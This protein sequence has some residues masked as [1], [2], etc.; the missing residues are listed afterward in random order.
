MG[1]QEEM[2]ERQEKYLKIILKHNKPEFKDIRKEITREYN[3]SDETIK[4]DLRRLIEEKKIIKVKKKYFVNHDHKDHRN[5]IRNYLKNKF[6]EEI[7]EGTINMDAILNDWKDNLKGFSKTETNYILKFSEDLEELEDNFLI[8]GI[9]ESKIDTSLIEEPFSENFINSIGNSL[10]SFRETP[11]FSD[12]VEFLSIKHFLLDGINEL[13]E[14]L[15][16][17]LS[18]YFTTKYPETKS[19]KEGLKKRLIQAY[20]KDL[21]NKMEKNFIKLI[22]SEYY[23]DAE[24]NDLKE[25]ILDFLDGNLRKLR[26]LFPFKYRSILN[27]L[28]E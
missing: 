7:R 18:G 22:I 10:E 16:I 28:F 2:R 20:E 23:E 27:A 26:F 13:S 24:I 14:N 15:S 21:I 17:S 1:K 11:Y 4:R 9:R 3:I 8:A 19:D 5:L 6:Q 25:E 12:F